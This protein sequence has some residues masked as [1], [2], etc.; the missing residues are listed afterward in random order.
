MLGGEIG[1]FAIQ[2]GRGDHQGGQWCVEGVVWSV[3]ADDC[4]HIGVVLVVIVMVLDEWTWRVGI[5]KKWIKAESCEDG[6]YIHFLDEEK[7]KVSDSVTAVHVTMFVVW[8]W[9]YNW[10]FIDVIDDNDVHHCF[11][12]TQVSLGS[13]LYSIAMRPGVSNSLPPRP[14]WKLYWCDSGCWWYQLNTS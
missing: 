9:S 7:I 11:Y 12:R 13:G 14:F 4:V 2:Y 6:I 3:G 1:N 8:T 5:Y 10:L